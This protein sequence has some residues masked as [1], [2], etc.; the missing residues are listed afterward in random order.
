MTDIV[1]SVPED[2]GALDRRLAPRRVLFDRSLLADVAC[3][4]E[5]VGRRGDEAIRD[6]TARHDR[7]TSMELRVSDEQ[8][9]ACMRSMSSDLRD[10]IEVGIRH[11]EEVN[12][13][14][15]PQDWTKEIRPGTVV[16]EKVTPL[17][18]VGLWV[19]ARKGPLVSTALMLTAAARVAGVTRIVVGM[20]P[21]E[22][23]TP[24]PGTVAAAHLAGAHEFL[25]GNG[26]AMIAGLT[27]GTASVPEVDGIFGPGPGA[28]AAAMGT[29]YSYGKRTVVGI[30]PTDGMILADESA[31]PEVLARDLMNEGEHGPDSASVLVTT[32]RSIAECVASE[33]EGLMDA[34][35]AHRRVF[36]KQVF[37]EQGMG[38]IVVAPDLDAACGVVNR[39]A[40]EHL[41]IS[42]A[43]EMTRKALGKI[44][45]AGEILLGHDTPF[46]AANY[47]IGITA[48]LP[49]NGFAR[50]FSGVTCRDMI[51]YSTIGSLDRGA[52]EGLWPMIRA[53]GEYEGLPCHV[54]AARVR[55]EDGR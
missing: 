10:G 34:T 49:T 33:I 28:I 36:L 44:T 45:Q 15:L 47:G 55:V 46:S 12:R 26:V 25:L 2:R 29:A 38:C 22:D 30:G 42:C 20:P 6:A 1:F 39:F 8:I 54:E 40:P 27:V 19:P 13:A 31:L 5:D 51:T 17:E 9:D 52:L 37:G 7:V 11:I 3:I 23:G 32:S 41:M 4:F 53:I 35:P 50:S 48:V 14:L 16:G 18:T 43:E 24:D 21:R